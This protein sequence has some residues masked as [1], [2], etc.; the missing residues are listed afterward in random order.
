MATAQVSPRQ[1]IREWMRESM[2]IGRS[3]YALPHRRRYV[4]LLQVLDEVAVRPQARMLEIGAG[5]GFFGDLLR[6]RYAWDVSGVDC[7]PELVEQCRLHGF[8]AA[9][10]DLDGDSLPFG[11][12]WFDVVLFDS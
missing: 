1:A 8:P 7:V 9:L 10:C 5:D 2:H 6:R 12:D 3:R 11:S 4:T